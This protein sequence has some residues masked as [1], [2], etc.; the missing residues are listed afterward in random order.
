ML[1]G[2]DKARSLGL[3][4]LAGLSVL[5]ATLTPARADIGPYLVIDAA[6]GAVLEEHEATRQWYPAS[7]TKMM[8]AY[9]ALRAVREGRLTFQSPVVQSANSL[10]QPPSKMGFKAGTQMT[11][12]TALTMLMVKSANDVAVAIAE[13]VAGSEP[14]FI[15]MMN[16]EARRLGMRDSMFVN[17]HGLPDNRQISSAADLAL[18][19]MA[20]KRDFPEAHHF[21]AHPGMKFGKKTLRSANREFLQRVP[22]AD[23]L[24]TGYICNSGYNVAAS[25]TR[26][27]RTV[28]AIVLGAGSGLERTAFS[29]QVIDRGFR[30]RGSGTTVTML[31]RA[32]TPPPADGYCKRNR[33]PGPE[34]ILARFDMANPQKTRSAAM[35][36]SNLDDNRPV[37]PGAPQQGGGEPGEDGEDVPAAKGKGKVDWNMILDRTV[38]VEQ[39]AYAPVTVAIGLP[40]GAQAAAAA[41]VAPVAPAAPA[42]TEVAG[43]PQAGVGLPQSKPLDLRPAGIVPGAVAEPAP[44]DIFRALNA[45]AT[46][47]PKP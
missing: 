44:G 19:A 43:S 21:Y 31:P 22:G 6:T 33:K 34:E 35:A 30:T 12:Q 38:G 7:L 40:K 36:L 41:P 16:A 47:A 17:P 32:G 8:T 37:L 23:G 27:G 3:A 42:M 29:R 14:A 46:P 4:A 25:A 39:V 9:V 1:G 26:N 45:P 2:F 18:L 10:A 15:D 24:K 5:S 11:L 20:L 28:I 13:A